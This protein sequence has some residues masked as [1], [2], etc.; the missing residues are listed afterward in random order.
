[1]LVD[2]LEGV[3]GSLVFVVESEL[4]LVVLQDVSGDLHLL[5]VLVELSKLSELLERGWSPTQGSFRKIILV[6][7]C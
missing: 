6:S 3:H 5:V 4:I 2:S 7:D 1:M